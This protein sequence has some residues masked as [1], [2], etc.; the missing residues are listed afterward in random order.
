MK[1]YSIVLLIGI[2]SACSFVSLNPEAKDVVVSS[3]IND[4]TTCKKINDITVSVWKKA[5]TFQSQEKTEDQL[6]ILARNQAANLK[7][8]TVVATSTVNQGQRSYAVY[9]CTKQ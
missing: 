8:N 9:N 4:S 7:G 3:T 1:K 5:D 6:D 2:L